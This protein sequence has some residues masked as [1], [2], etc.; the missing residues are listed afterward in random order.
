LV[1]GFTIVN[2]DGFGIS[3]KTGGGNA[4]YGN[5]IGTDETNSQTLGNNAGGIQIL[6]S[7]NNHIGFSE[8]GGHNTIA[9]NIGSGIV[10][11]GNESSRNSIRGNRIGTDETGLLDI[12][13]GGDGISIDDTNDNTIGT[14]ASEDANIIRFNKGNGVNILSGSGNRIAANLIS[15]NTGL[16]IDLEP[17]GISANDAADADDGANGLQNFPVLTETWKSNVTTV[18]GTLNSNPSSSFLIQ[19][20][21][22]LECDGSG[23]G[24]GAEFLGT[25]EV[26]TDDDG[27]GPFVVILDQAD[28]FIS[29]TA[30]DAFGNT[31]EFS[32]CLEI[33]DPTDSTD[34]SISTGTPEL[35][36]LELNPGEFVVARADTSTSAAIT[37]DY[38]ITGTTSN[39][40]DYAE[41]SGSVQI[42]PGETTQTIPVFLFADN[43]AEGDENLVLTLLEGD[44]YTLGSQV[45]AEIMINDLPSGVWTIEN[46]PNNPNGPGTGILDDP[47]F[48]GILNLLEYA[49]FLDPNVADIVDLPIL[50]VHVD[51][52]G[53]KHLAITFNKPTAVNDLDYTVEVSDDLDK[54]RYNGDGFFVAATAEISQVDNGD[55]TETLS[56]Y[57]LLPFSEDIDR[58]IRLRVVPQS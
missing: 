2:F 50:S 5:Q 8:E 36:E 1:R 27:N 45:T 12:G 15:D 58:F 56:I 31:S 53:V 6:N 21:Q 46:F 26:T 29:A 54:W 3:I 25:T 51:Q 38:S 40:N 28:G 43:E 23:N 44:S 19:F 52:S 10:I 32:A 14:S 30:T 47:D 42:G 18:L 9:G 4:V 13:N 34:L 17:E 20:F 57:D 37:V 35:T 49:L 55:G 16:G 7:A 39:G 48:D 11:S 22:S 24:Q 33:L 41:L